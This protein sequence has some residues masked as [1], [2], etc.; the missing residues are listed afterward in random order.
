M[1]IFNIIYNI[2]LIKINNIKVC[3][4]TIGKNE[5]KYIKEFIDHYKYYGIDKIMIY[6]NNDIN[7]ERFELE[8]NN[9]IKNNFVE[10]IDYRG[11]EKSQIT[12]MKDCYKNNYLKYDWLLFYDIDE[13]IYLKEKNIKIFLAKNKLNSCNRIYLN[14][15][16]HLDNEQIKYKNESLFKRFPKYKYFFDENHAFVKTMIRGKI[17]NIKIYNNHVINFEEE[18][19]N[20]FGKK[21]LFNLSVTTDNPNNNRYYIDHFYFK[22]TEE[23]INKRNRGSVFYG[24]KSRI[25]LDFIDLYFKY[26]KITIEKIQY[27]ENKT[28][29]N[30]SKYKDFIGINKL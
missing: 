14:W 11:K 1:I 13:F 26:N 2:K 29:F 5:N 7:G 15:V 24:N 10:I 12:S 30:L 9:Y 4:C 6:D 21:K 28:L 16:N 25:N 17:P 27:F 22:S 8:L 18:S 23:Y 3:I 20:A 19:C